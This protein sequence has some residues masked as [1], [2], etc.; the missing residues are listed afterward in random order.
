MN[1]SDLAYF[2]NILNERKSQIK[3]NISDSTKEM[4]SLNVSEAS[5]EVDQA[6]ISIDRNIEQVI[7]SQQSRELSE[8]EYAINKISNGTYGVCEMCEEEIRVPRLKVKPHAKYCI[9]CRE[10]IEKDSNNKRI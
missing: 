5:D 8:I 10:L 1:E 3:K 6:S 9:V 2:R 4:E 7:T